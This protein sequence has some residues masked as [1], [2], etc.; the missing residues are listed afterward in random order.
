[1]SKMQVIK[2]SAGSGKTYTLARRYI[3]ELL[4][5]VEFSGTVT[6]GKAEYKIKKLRT[7]KDYYQHIL[8]ITF[9]NKATNEMKRRIVDE[10]SILAKDPN[11]SDFY[12]N[13]WK[14]KLPCSKDDL[15]LAAKNA[16]SAILFNYSD[17]KVSTIDSFFQ[18]V[19]RSFAREL[20]RDY[21]YELMLDGDYAAAVAAHNFLLSLGDT[22]RR[23]GKGKSIPEK[24][25]EQYIRDRVNEDKGWKTIF[26]SDDG[27]LSDFAKKINNEF[28]REHMDELKAYLA[29]NVGEF[30]YIT[31]FTKL[32]K[33]KAQK[34][35]AEYNAPH[36]QQ[37]F[38]S[39]CSNAGLK[40]SDFHKKW[41]LHNMFNGEPCTEDS[42][43][44]FSTK[45]NSLE[46]QFNKGA[47]AKVTDGDLEKIHTLIA[48]R[49]KC[50]DYSELLKDMAK[51][52]SYVGLMG[53]IGKKLE[54]YRQESN[55]VLIADTNELIGRVV[56]GS[57]TP[58]I[59]ERTGT[60]I[61]SYMLDEF[62]DTSRKQYDNFKP[63][64]NE[65]L[66]GG[67][68]DLVIGD[69]KQAIYRFRNAD[70]SLFRE[71]IDKDFAGYLMQENLDTNWRSHNSII[72]FNNE[73]TKRMLEVFKDYKL[74]EKTYKPTGNDS[75]YQQKVSPPKE[76]KD[77]G[78]VRVHFGYEKGKDV[79][80]D[81]IEHLLDMH[82]R[83]D[84]KDINILV[85]ERADG[86]TIVDAI[87][88]H[89]RDCDKDKVIPVVSGE[90]MRLSQSNAVRRV[91]GMLRFI[92]LTS[93]AIAEDAMDDATLKQMENDVKAR[94]ARTRMKKQRQFSVLEAFESKVGEAQAGNRNLKPDEVGTLL[95]DCFKDAKAKAQGT[96]IEQMNKYAQELNDR[97]PDQNTR[98]MSL[99]NIVEHLV[100]SLSE[101]E[102]D[103]ERLFLY[104]LLNYV[105]E[106]ASQR[107]GGTVREFLRYWDQKKDT[108]TVPDAGNIDAIQVY[109]IHKSKG[110]EADCV[111]IPIA[112]WDLDTGRDKEY[113]VDR[114]TW[115][116]S[117]GKAL[118]DEVAPGKWTEDMVPPILVM[119][120]KKTRNLQWLP[121]FG[122][123]VNRQD[124]DVLIDN[125]NKTYVAFTR[126]RKELHIYCVGNEPRVTP[127]TYNMGRVL[128]S[129]IRDSSDHMG[130]AQVVEGR[131][132]DWG[133]PMPE[134]KRDDTNKDKDSIPELPAYEVSK[135]S[136]DVTLPVDDAPGALMTSEKGTRLHA[137]MSRLSY[138]SQL[139]K[140]LGYCE[141]RGIISTREKS[142]LHAFLENRLEQEPYAQ[143]F[144]DDNVVYNE[145]TMLVLEH[146]EKSTIRPDR[147]VRHQDGSFTIVD[148]KFGA[149]DKEHSSQV[150]GYMNHLARVTGCTVRGYL[151]YIDIANGKDDIEEVQ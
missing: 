111:V 29:G 108:L 121:L 63:L 81:L 144:A 103:T 69:S 41:I 51:R 4:F 115:L 84:W 40:E 23:T 149:A 6:D 143:W 122:S 94:A 136:V 35:E 13:E 44:K 27:S 61:N 148:Y 88:N 54:E 90:M 129:I 106:F 91:I 55:T 89:N 131:Q 38:L 21:N 141:R 85:N 18:G 139:E 58:F 87:M 53:E 110:L 125:V 133:A 100:K 150:R 31:E 7:E 32:L 65:S 25:V 74:L 119:N 98:T 140:V 75:D 20:N 72:K 132:Y 22:A 138:A 76:K 10:L 95:N 67:N 123:I 147:I 68:A 52:L 137:V 3:E 45:E 99:V 78:L 48:A 97:L 28:F 9:T 47:Y 19:L 5:V 114:K 124:E 109:T 36:W 107:N 112:D 151:W 15:K 64:L 2:A 30:E 57:D 66:A 43:R 60:W 128:R 62:Q 1:M 46:K 117:G 116:N 127:T 50:F 39:I 104:A 118:L 70:P 130:F 96:E 17:F 92:D 120:K 145:R 93:Y 82:K 134:L 80:G 83:F 73:F 37:D 105:V 146:D 42:Q 142:E 8:A 77:A 49:L 26:G 135:H 126:P 113:W 12:K 79:T 71:E 14:G 59:Y 11:G 101:E 33:D 24:W 16:L 86:K 102:R 34:Y 56:K